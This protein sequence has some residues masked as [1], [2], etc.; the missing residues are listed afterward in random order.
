LK[1]FGIFLIFSF[2]KNASKQKG[3]NSRK[4]EST[5]R[6]GAQRRRGGGRKVQALLE[7]ANRQIL[8][9]EEKPSI[10]KEIPFFFI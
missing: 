10:H 9:K 3:F 5:K 7:E 6:P 1:S 2:L 8:L 4:T